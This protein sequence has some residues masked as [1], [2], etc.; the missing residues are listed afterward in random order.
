MD[1]EMTRLEFSEYMTAFERRLDGRFVR[2]DRRLDALDGRLDV[3]DGRFDDVDKRLGE[4]K[5]SMAVQFEETRREI[6]LSLEVVEALGE[7]MDRRFVEMQREHAN[8]TA[9]L[10]DAVR[11]VA[12]QAKPVEAKKPHRRRT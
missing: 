9:P 7:R 5:Q 3:V 6:K 11:H 10:E 1:D 4:L 12:R 8:K 2:L